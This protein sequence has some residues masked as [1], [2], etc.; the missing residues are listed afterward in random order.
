MGHNA[1][2]IT[3][4]HKTLHHKGSIT[5][6]HDGKSALNQ[7]AKTMAKDPNCAHFDI[8]RAIWNLWKELPV[9][10]LKFKHVKGHH[11]K[12]QPMAHV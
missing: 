2:V 3:I 7:A 8:V 5:I 4:D 10:T 11:D 9:L 12:G 6:V 1:H